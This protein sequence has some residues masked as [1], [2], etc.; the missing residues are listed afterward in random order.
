M[1]A[2]SSSDKPGQ[3]LAQDIDPQ[4]LS[5]LRDEMLRFATLQLRDKHLAED[6]VQDAIAAALKSSSGA[7]RA[8]LRTWVF[9][10]LRNKIID[11]IRERSRHPTQSLVDEDDSDLDEQFDERGHWRKNQKPANWGHPEAVLANE[12]FW[13]IFEACL[14][15]LPE[16]TARV[17]MM[18]EH[19]GLEISE[20]CHELA[21]S[22]SNCWVIMHRARMR[23]RL[24]LEKNLLQTGMAL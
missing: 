12:Q 10:I 24:C 2:D 19:I 14:N 4:Q 9:A 21:I 7:E 6:A 8:S 13:P 18:R 5:A 16:N 20:I 17:F 1:N 23:L 15:H 11:V 22:E 3:S